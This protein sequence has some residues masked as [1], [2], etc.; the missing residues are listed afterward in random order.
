MVCYLLKIFTIIRE[1]IIVIKLLYWVDLWK[2]STQSIIGT[3]LSY[4]ATCIK[5][6]KLVGCEEVL[7]RFKIGSFTEI[8]IVRK[9]L[10]FRAESFV[11]LA[12]FT[13]DV[14]VS[15]L[16]TEKLKNTW[17]FIRNVVRPDSSRFCGGAKPCHELSQIRIL[18]LFLLL[19]SYLV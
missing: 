6:F 7:D 10:V 13:H 11:S 3:S 4:R 18:V 16:K 19:E 14:V 12:I 5:K 15:L 17:R 2:I 1:E 9:T 8:S